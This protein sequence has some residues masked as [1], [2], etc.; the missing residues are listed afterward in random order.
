LLGYYCLVW[1]TFKRTAHTHHTR[2][3][4]DPAGSCPHSPHTPIH[5]LPQHSHTGHIWPFGKPQHIPGH[6]LSDVQAAWVH[7]SGTLSP[8]V[9]TEDR[10]PFPHPPLRRPPHAC[11]GRRRPV[12]QAGRPKTPGVPAGRTTLQLLAFL[13]QRFTRSINRHYALRHDISTKLWWIPLPGADALAWRFR[14]PTRSARL[15]FRAAGVATTTTAL[16]LALPC[17]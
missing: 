13:Y 14:L 8:S 12:G 11:L 7:A 9:H 10:T 1:G 17:L 15:R 4:A 3:T 16:L 2:H 5:G 6:G